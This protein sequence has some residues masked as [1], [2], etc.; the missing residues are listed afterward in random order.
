MNLKMATID[1]VGKEP[2]DAQLY[3]AV[4]EYAKNEFGEELH[5]DYYARAW[6]ALA[7]E[8]SGKY[9]VIG[10]LGIRNAIDVC[11]FHVTPLTMDKDGLKLAEQA[12]DMMMYRGTAYLQDLGNSGNVVLIHVSATAER[13]WRR[14]L[15]K[16]GATPAERYQVK[17]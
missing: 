2:R 3:S 16:I 4:Q 14:F 12:R 11:T 7:V 8:E 5:F 17:I 9:V 13:Y 1:F 15:A 10:V 6:A